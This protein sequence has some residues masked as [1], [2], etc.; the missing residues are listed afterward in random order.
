MNIQEPKK[1]EKISLMKVLQDDK[2]H[3]SEADEEMK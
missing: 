2:I 1:E 3:K